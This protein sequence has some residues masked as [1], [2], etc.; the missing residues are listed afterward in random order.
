MAMRRKLDAGEFVVL[1][2]MEPPKG[3]D[4]APMVGHAQ[5]V[6]GRVDAFLVP[7]MSNAVMRMSALGGAMVLQSRGMETVMQI[8]CRDRNRLAL[9]ADL[10]AAWA[11]G[12]PSVMAVT[13]EDP[14]YGDHHQTRAVHDLD[15]LALLKTIKKLCQ[16]RDLA[17]I[18]LRGAPGF[19]VGAL[20]LLGA[21][22]RSPEIEIEEM[23][24]KAEAGAEFFITPPIFDLKVM[25]PYL[26]R[27]DSPSI[28]LIPTVMLLKSL[29][30][31]RYMARNVETAF[32]PDALIARLQQATDK[33]RECLRIA[34]ET[35]N[36]IRGAG[37]AGVMLATLGW[38]DRLPDIIAKL[39]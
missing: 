34:A 31:A 6:K 5:Q 9:Q 22:G 13:G 30:M 11:C 25:D 33:V 39:K 17:G 24:K 10:L 38:E 3:V 23:E 2:E 26:K 21:K 27:I 1:A 18:E 20:A 19:S 7:E 36:A 29:G 14:A 8:N 32:I 15:L 37:F 16:G 12:I 35:T 28:K 4:V